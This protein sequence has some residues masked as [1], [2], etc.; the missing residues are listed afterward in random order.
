MTTLYPGALDTTT[1][2]KNDAADGTLT[3][4]THKTHHNNISD[5]IMAMQLEMGVNPS[6][7]FT[8]IAAAL[9]QLDPTSGGVIVK[10]PGVA[11]QILPSADVVALAIRAQGAG[12]TSKLLR[13][14]NSSGTEV[15]SFDKTGKMDAASISV[16]GTLLAASHLSNGV[17]GSGAVV[18]ATSPTITTPSITTPTLTGTPV[19]PT[20][21]G[22]DN[23]TKVATTAFVASALAGITS[24]RTSSFAIDLRNPQQASNS[25]N[26]FPTVTGALST[27]NYEMWHWEFLKDV[28]GNLFGVVHVPDNLAGTPNP[29]ILLELGANATTGVTRMTALA[30]PVADGTALGSVSLQGTT[31]DTT[32]PG[33]ARARKKVTL[34]LTGIVFP[35]AGDLMLV[36]IQHEGTHANDTLAVNTELYGAW[37]IC[38][39]T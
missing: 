21:T 31:Q 24:V 20:P 12:M 25:G 28:I 27:N 18:L 2:L 22:G 5:A 14:L 15:A 33:T 3:A 6:G 1:Q 7:S 32:V 36:Q 11:Q 10:T 35:S 34:N 37:L 29:K 39:V 23:S 9:A 38:D 16:A 8:D 30:A 13:I 26:V 17:Q 19:A 4:T